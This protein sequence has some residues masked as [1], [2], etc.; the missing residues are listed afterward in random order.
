M[1]EL[2]LGNKGDNIDQGRPRIPGLSGDFADVALVDA[3]NEHSIDLDGNAQRTGLAD[4]GQLGPDQRLRCRPSHNK[5]AVQ[6]DGG[7]NLLLYSRINSVDCD[8][9]SLYAHVGD[10]LRMLLQQKPVGA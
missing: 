2:M 8:G 9:Y 7:A 1:P 3:W 10:T 5:L 4:T 6:S